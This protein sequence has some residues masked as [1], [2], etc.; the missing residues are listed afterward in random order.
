MRRNTIVYHQCVISGCW[1]I[2]V[3]HL[4]LVDRSFV[5]QIGILPSFISRGTPH[6]AALEA[7]ISEGRKLNIRILPA[8]AGFFDMPQSW[9]MGQIIWLP[10]RRKACCGFLHQKKRPGLKPRTRE[11]EASMLTSRPPKPLCHQWTVTINIG[12]TLEGARGGVVVKAVRYIPA[13]GGFDCYSC[14]LFCIISHV[15]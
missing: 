12:I 11:P 5:P 15:P 10:L 6:H 1:V 9:D 7:S 14:V 4:G 13:G 8:A 3:M 2:R